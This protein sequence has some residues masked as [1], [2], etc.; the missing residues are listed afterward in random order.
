LEIL[1]EL[2]EFL[3]ALDRI[4]LK[5]FNSLIHHTSSLDKLAKHLGIST[6]AMRRRKQSLLTRLRHHLEE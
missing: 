5:L 6:Y 4:D 1:A 2:E 3:D